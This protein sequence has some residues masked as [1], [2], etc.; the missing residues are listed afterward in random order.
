VLHARGGEGGACV[1]GEAAVPADEAV[2]DGP[3]HSRGQEH[4]EVRH[5]GPARRGRRAGA[6]R[7]G[8]QQRHRRRERGGRPR[9]HRKASGALALEQVSSAAR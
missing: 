9:G 5:V 1:P 2:L 7:G 6:Q 3:G 8:H 4:A